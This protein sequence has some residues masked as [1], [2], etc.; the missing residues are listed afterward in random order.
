M[1]DERKQKGQPPTP[2]VDLSQLFNELPSL[3]EFSFDNPR[4]EGPNFYRQ[5]EYSADPKKVT[6]RETREAEAS[7]LFGS[8]PNRSTP[9]VLNKNPNG[10]TNYLYIVTKLQEAGIDTSIPMEKRVFSSERITDVMARGTDRSNGLNLLSHHGGDD[11]EWLAMIEYGLK[12]H[13]TGRT[14]Y[15]SRLS[16]RDSHELLG[17]AFGDALVIYDAR[18]LLDCQPSHNKTNSFSNG[19]KLFVA[20]PRN[21]LLAIIK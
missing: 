11:G 19:H 13:E 17:G 16:E 18:G 20:D 15:T 6:N 2:S 21:V 3:Q 1:F 12:T 9:V 4:Q 10:P 7:E 8:Q 5:S 14:T